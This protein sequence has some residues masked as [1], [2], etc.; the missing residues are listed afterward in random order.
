MIEK[1]ISILPQPERWR[2]WILLS[3][4]VKS[5]FFIYKINEKAVPNETYTSIWAKEQRD[6]K[7][8]IGPMEDFIQTGIYSYD[9]RL[10]GYGILYGFFRLFLTVSHS[11]N[12][13]IVL[14]LLLAAWSVYILAWIAKTIFRKKE[15]F[16]YSFFLYLLST[17]T[18]IYDYQLLT[19]S[20]C[21]SALVFSFYF[22]LQQNWKNAILSGLFLSWSIFLRPANAPLLILWGLFHLLANRKWFRPLTWNW[23]LAIAFSIPFIILD[24]LW[25]YRNYQ[26]YNG[27][28]P[29]SRTIYYT[30]LED[31]YTLS[32]FH[33]MNAYGASVCWWQPA[34]ETAYFIRKN[35]T[36]ESISSRAHT[37]ICNA[38]SFSLL[39]TLVR[40]I[41]DHPENTEQNKIKNQMAIA[42]FDRCT[43][44]IKKE[45]PFL[46]HIESR[47]RYFVQFIFHWGTDNLF[48]RLDKDLNTFSFSIKMLYTLL[49]VFVICFGLVGCI[50]LFIRA[51][52][53]PAL[54]FLT[55][56]SLY[57]VMVF[58]L[59]LKMDEYRY[60][61]PAYPFLLLI[62][63][64]R[65]DQVICFP[66]I[67]LWK[68]QNS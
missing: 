30:G 50:F 26:K 59:V 15:F 58:P 53:N 3:I 19:E 38:D 68:N 57:F 5:L 34:G 28:Y 1:I 8:Y 55:L 45:K 2:F 18:S 36:L 46:Y 14:Q 29:L 39:R 31:K 24:G 4:L 25:L 22:A 65:L 40:D 54:L 41:D 42:L 9:Y 48:D 7:T 63:I 61:A 21:I 11:L 64:Y 35:K 37:K 67:R 6:S 66:I 32:M 27:F 49:Y 44:A 52:Q 23:K 43:E 17:Y 13:L 62:S 16:Y 12:A 51:N 47:L 10:P 20:F 56:T 33:F 60:L